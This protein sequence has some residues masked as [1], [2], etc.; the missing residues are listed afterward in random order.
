MSG[1][2]GSGCIWVALAL[3]VGGS[4][5]AGAAPRAMAQ[6]AAASARATHGSSNTGEE[7]DDA[8]PAKNFLTLPLN[9]H[10]GA[11]SVEIPGQDDRQCMLCHTT[12]GWKPAAFAHERAG[13]ELK[14]AHQH[15]LCRSCHVKDLTTR[16]ATTC[17]GCH[18]DPHRADFGQRC[19]GCHEEEDWVPL[20]DANAHRRTNFPLVGRHALIPC[21]ECHTE[22]RDRRFVRNT[23]ALASAAGGATG[24]AVPCQT[25]HSQDFSS[26]AALGIVPHNQLGWAPPG[27]D[28]NEC[29]GGFR[30]EG[31]KFAQHDRCFQ[32][33]VGVH[34]GIACLKCHTSLAAAKVDGLCQTNTASCIGCH[35]HTQSRTDPLHVSPPVP[36]YQFKD[37]KCYE[38]HAFTK[39]P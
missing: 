10:S 7:G 33:T 8:T 37:R 22:L 28:C 29:H 16:V 24:K 31:A 5:V 23:G 12:S 34:S 26:R 20:F 39:G 9:P 38:C 27:R 4:T 21:T 30:F 15:A 32:N 3:A 36:G 2:T 17:A 18:P 19:E 1:W 35:E 6:R 14:G 13:F 11:T 25:C